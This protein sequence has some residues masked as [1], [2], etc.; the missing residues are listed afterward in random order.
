MT[1]PRWP[2]RGSAGAAGPLDGSSR[3]EQKHLVLVPLALTLALPLAATPD[4][5]EAVR[6]ADLAASR[7]V[8]ARDA[9]A[10][11]ALLDPE[12]TFAGARGLLSGR[13]AV[14]KAWS[15]FFAPAGPRL[16]WAPERAA[17]A[18]SGDL[19]F[20]TGSFVWEGE[21]RP[22]ERGRETGSYVSVWRRGA[23]G[24]WRIVLDASL[25]PAG[26]LGPGLARAPVRSLASR[27]GD[28][29]ARIGTWTRGTER[30]AFL[31]VV[32][33][34]ASGEEAVVDSAFVLQGGAPP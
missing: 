32:R 31:T 18:A 14:A 29:A 25:E 8:E 19:A 21:V 3:G 6:A 20:T 16:A 24:A 23:D 2:G 34:G 1:A 22:G 26:R 5:A 12:A 30:G 4:P 7:A 33:R 27:A 17:V 13:E 10:F 28:L 11:E 9:A 15:S